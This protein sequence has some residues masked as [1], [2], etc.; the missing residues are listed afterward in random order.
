MRDFE[1]VWSLR[2]YITQEG[3]PDG[4]FR[5]SAVWRTHDDGMRYAE[6]GYLKLGDAAP[7]S[8]RRSCFWRDDLSVYFE[9]GRF[10]HKV[11]PDGGS[12][13][14]WCDPDLYHVTYD[15]D[16]W[17]RFRIRWRVSGAR[18]NYR[19]E[20]IYDDRRQVSK[21]GGPLTPMQRFTVKPTD[22]AG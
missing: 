14:H 12:T 19:I 7:I 9:D 4:E 10:F 11:P 15:F 18:K 5:G 1:G 8:A 16:H 3:A 6:S 21:T 17:P 22:D 13:E 20:C 2:K